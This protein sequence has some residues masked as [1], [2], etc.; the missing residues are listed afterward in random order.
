MVSAAARIALPLVVFLVSCAP[1]AL[2]PLATPLLSITLASRGGDTE[3]SRLIAE[4]EKK[5]DWST[6]KQLAQAHIARR[7]DDED[8]LMVLGYAQARLGEYAP[9]SE[10]FARMV[11]R[12]PEEIDGWNM[13]GEAQRLN[14]RYA[15]AA[16]TLQRATAIDPTS[17]ITR[18]LL[19]EALRGDGRLEHAKMAYREALR[20]EPRFAPAWLGLGTVLV[21]TGPQDELKAVLE[22][23]E[24]LDPALARE[25]A[26]RQ[27]ANK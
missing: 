27:A 23:L 11:R 1:M 8:W 9:A 13:L 4:L 10:T 2:L 17:P 16:H 3:T 24:L 20:L 14:G 26:R 15:E 21:A 7:G 18:Y 12:S 5:Q 19:G 6:L 25:L 22:Q